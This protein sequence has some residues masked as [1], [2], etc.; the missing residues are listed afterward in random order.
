MLESAYLT[1]NSWI[2]GASMYALIGSFLWGMVSVILSPCHLA[3]IPLI[4]AYVGGQQTQVNTRQAGVYSVAFSLGLFSSIALV[5]ITCAILGR[6]LGDVGIFWQVLVGGVL[7]WVALGMLGVE[8]C[9]MSG[10]ILQRLNFHGIIGALGLGWLME[11]C[12]EPVP[13]GSSPRSWPSSRCRIRSY[14]ASCLSWYSPWGTA[15]LS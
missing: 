1:I 3:S 12:Q 8:S 4:V 11:S 14:S 10:S 2:V 5:G 9:S 7:I 13:S 15:Y 6:M